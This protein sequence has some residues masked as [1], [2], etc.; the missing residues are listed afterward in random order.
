MSVP[1][2]VMSTSYTHGVICRLPISV[3][4][5]DSSTAIGIIPASDCLLNVVYTMPGKYPQAR[6]CVKYRVHKARLFAHHC[7]LICSVC[8][9][10]V[11]VAYSRRISDVI[12]CGNCLMLCAQF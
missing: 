10:L 7:C 1:F 6:M 8:T 4:S 11:I 2:E 12:Y 3:L 9:A 5:R